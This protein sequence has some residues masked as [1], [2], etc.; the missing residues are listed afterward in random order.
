MDLFGRSRDHSFL[1]VILLPEVTHYT[2]LLYTINDIV[3]HLSIEVSYSHYESLIEPWARLSP[4][5][6]VSHSK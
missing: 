4:R 5:C 1:S 2:R 6:S 3:F